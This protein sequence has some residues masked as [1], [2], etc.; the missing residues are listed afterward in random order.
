MSEQLARRD[1]PLFLG[2]RRAILLHGR[3]KVQFPL[4]VKLQDGNGGNWFGN[5]PQTEECPR[6]GRGIV[7]QI[8]HAKSRGPH[9]FAVQNYGRANAGTL[10]ADMKLQT[11]FSISARF[12]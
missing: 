1:G 11:A 9:G 6:R 10:F 12:P 4:L 5:R 8:R 3:V 7:F 2:K